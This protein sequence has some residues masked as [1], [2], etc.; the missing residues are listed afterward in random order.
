MKFRKLLLVLPIIGLLVFQWWMIKYQTHVF[1]EL[2]HAQVQAMQSNS[3]EGTALSSSR[4]RDPEW[5]SSP[6]IPNVIERKLYQI[7]LV[8]EGAILNGG[9]TVVDAEIKLNSI[10]EFVI[11]F[12][13]ALKLGL[14][15]PMPEFWSGEGSTPAMTLARK[16]VGVVTAVFYA[17]LLG[18]LIGVI[19]YRKNIALWTILMFCLIGILVYAYIYPNVGTLVR[20]RYGFYMMLISF[21]VASIVEVVL[22]RLK[23]SHNNNLN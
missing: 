23:N 15:S 18:L 16:I 12:P 14:L 6:Y 5:K 3:S 9:N 13:R 21:G 4:A 22:C 10:K 8:R 19:N 7:S 17:C 20:Y 11:Y 1:K 2:S